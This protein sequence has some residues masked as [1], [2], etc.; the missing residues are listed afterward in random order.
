[1]CEL[2][3]LAKMRRARCQQLHFTGAFNI[4]QQNTCPE[5]QIDLFGQLA[6]SGEDHVTRGFP[7]E[8][9]YSLQFSSGNDVEPSA[10]PREQSQDREIRIGLHRITDGVVAFPK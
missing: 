7:S 2:R 1:N 6:D 3:R 8:F 10:K 5:R 4:E 9:L